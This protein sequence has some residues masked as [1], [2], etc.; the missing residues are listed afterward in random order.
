MLLWITHNASF[1]GCI[2]VRNSLFEIIYD[3]N[4]LGVLLEFVTEHFTQED[5]Q[6]IM[7]T[8]KGKSGTTRANPSIQMLFNSKGPML[9]LDRFDKAE[10]PL[11]VRASDKFIWVRNDYKLNLY[12]GE[13]GYVDWVDP[14]AGELGIVTGQ[15]EQ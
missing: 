5:H 13:I 8:R 15:S 2:P 4:P 1:E 14:D 3:D 7:P 10:A 6:I 9:R 12:N 11:A